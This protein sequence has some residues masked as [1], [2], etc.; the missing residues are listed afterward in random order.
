M[1][2]LFL[3]YWFRGYVRVKRD[4]GSPGRNFRVSLPFDGMRQDFAAFC[5]ETPTTYMPLMILSKG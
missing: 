1:C 4:W 3:F 2:S 5:K